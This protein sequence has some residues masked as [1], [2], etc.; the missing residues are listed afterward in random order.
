MTIGLLI[1]KLA[2]HGAKGHVQ[3]RFLRPREVPID[4][5]AVDERR[6]VAAASAQGVADRAHAKYQVHIGASLLE[7]EFE[8][9]LTRARQVVWR[10]RMLD[11]RDNLVLLLDSEKV[12][13]LAGIEDA[14]EVFQKALVGDL[15]V[16]EEENAR[17]IFEARE[18]IQPL[19]ILAKLGDAIPLRPLGFSTLEPDDER[20]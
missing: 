15:R 17:G 4:G 8:D 11:V 7:E 19:E 14:A 16:V 13:H 1:R 20:C 9:A 5:G 18:P 3:E 6:E 2:S 12:G 10:G